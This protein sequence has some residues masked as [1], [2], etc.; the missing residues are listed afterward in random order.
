[1]EYKLDFALGEYVILE[2]VDKSTVL[3]ADEVA[4]IFKVISFGPS[5]SKVTAFTKSSQHATFGDLVMIFPN[6]LKEQYMEGKKIYFVY[7]NEI[8]ARVSECGQSPNP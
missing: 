5:S 2:P 7:Y 3:K 8:L 1:M 6:S 4:T